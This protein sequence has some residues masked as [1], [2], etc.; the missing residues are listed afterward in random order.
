MREMNDKF[1]ISGMVDFWLLVDFGW[2]GWLL[3]Y[4]KRKLHRKR[5]DNGIT[6]VSQRYQYGITT[7]RGRW[8]MG[9]GLVGGKLDYFK[10]W[11]FF[12][13]DMLHWQ[14]L[15]IKLKRMILSCFFYFTSGFDP[16]SYFLTI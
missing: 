12:W 3:D 15:I 1:G 4:T 10:K 5:I 7:V 8:V 9:W 11:G 6:A 13:S 2:L 16:L 14:D